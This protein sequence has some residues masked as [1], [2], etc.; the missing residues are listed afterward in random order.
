MTLGCRPP[1]FTSSAASLPAL[2]DAFAGPRG[3]LL[4][5]LLDPRRV[6]PPVGD[7]SLE[8]LD[9]DR[10]AHLVEARDHDHA[11]RVVHDDVHAGRLLDRA[12]VPPLAPDDPPLHVVRRDRDRP[13][14][15]L[16]GVL[17]RVP[18]HRHQRDLAR[19]LLRLFLRLL[20]DAAHD[21]RDLEP[22]F[23]LDAREQFGFASSRLRPAISWRRSACSSR[24]RSASASRSATAASRDF[25]G[26]P[27]VA[28][29]AT[30]PSARASLSLRSIWSSRL[31]EAALGLAH[32][33]RA[34]P[35]RR[36][37]SLSARA[38]CARIRAGPSPP[39]SAHRPSPA[40]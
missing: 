3:G 7:Q 13:H 16:A 26:P 27:R 10:L 36:R 37:T 14:R 25:G 4:D 12:D 19:L 1:R 2:I 31:P 8:R 28:Q 20:R 15:A 23:L 22:G 17:G 35:S 5:D 38:P 39:R 11:R 33:A 30:S 32:L 34:P 6:H 9:R 24:I 29:R 21:L 18:L 40:R